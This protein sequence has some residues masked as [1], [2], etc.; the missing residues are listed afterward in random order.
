[1]ITTK[2]EDKPLT[3]SINKQ[4]SKYGSLRTKERESKIELCNAEDPMKFLTRIDSSIKDAKARVKK[5]IDNSSISEEY[6][7]SFDQLQT[8]SD[9]NQSCLGNN[10]PLVKLD[11]TKLSPASTID[12]NHIDRLDPNTSASSSDV[13]NDMET[14]TTSN[15]THT[16]TSTLPSSMRPNNTNTFNNYTHKHNVTHKPLPQSCLSEPPD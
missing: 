7:S 1:M 10:I 2:M 5:S 13:P 9:I 6:E 4:Y 8:T 11:R 12:S 14:K 16:S 3:E 15:T